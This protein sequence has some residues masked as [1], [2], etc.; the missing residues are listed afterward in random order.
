MELSWYE[1]I[2]AKCS[3]TLNSYTTSEEFKKALH[4]EKLR[5]W[6]GKNISVRPVRDRHD[7][8][9]GNMGLVEKGGSES[10]D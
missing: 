1:I 5:N 3:R 9:C 6:K 8:C 2:F 7:L 4:E 10:A